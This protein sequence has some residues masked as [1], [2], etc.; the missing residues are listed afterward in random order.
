[1]QLSSIRR[2]MRLLVAASLAILMTNL[3]YGQIGAGGFPGR[4]VDIVEVTDHDDQV[5]IT[6]QFNCSV[7]YV[8]HLPASEGSEIRVQLQPFPDCGV[9]PG[10]PVASEI[11]PI[12]GGGGLV[13]AVRVDS[14]VPGQITLVFTLRKSEQFVIAQGVDPRGLRLR[15]IKPVTRK[16]QILLQPT[17]SVSNYAINLD[18]RTTPFEPEAVE[19]AHQLLQ[20]P[21][22]ISETVVEG[23]KWYR[24]RI[25]PIEQRAQANRLLEK[26]LAEYPRAWLAI[27]DDAVT[28]DL[29]ALSSEALPPVEHI[30]SDPP[31]DAAT[32]KSMLGQIRSAMSARDYPT[33]IRLL[34]K[35]QRQPEFPER[36]RVQE[37]LGLARER[38]GQLAHAKAEYE[39]YMRRYPK[40]E[41]AERI[42]LRLRILRAATAKSQS[43][44]QVSEAASRWRINGGVSQLFRYDGTRVDNTTPAGNV[45][46]G[47]TI[48]PNSTQTTTEDA[49]FNDVDFLARRRGDSID[50]MARMSAGY[51]K[52]FDAQSVGNQRRISIA[53]IELVDRSLGLLGR[54]GRQTR[55]QDGVLGTFDGLF[56]SYQWRPAWGVN[57]TAGYPVEETDAGVR[58]NRRFE[59]IALAYSPPGARWDASIFAVIQE[60]D[61]VRDRQAA[62]FEARYLASHASLVMVVDYDT[63]YHSLNTASF[64]GTVQLPARW[65]VSFDAERRNSP[66]LTTRNALIGQPAATI[67]ELEAQ[68]LQAGLPAQTIFQWARDRTPYTTDYSFT[69]TRP[70]GQRLQFSATAAV[71]QTS[72]TPASGAVDAQPGSG[73]ETTYQAQLYGSSLWFPGDFSVASLTYANTETGKV[74]TLGGSARFPFIGAWRIGPRITVNRRVLV[75]DDS[76]ELTYIPSVLL[77][78]QRGLK[79]LQF[80]VGGQL[81]KRDALLETQNTKRYYVSLSYRIGF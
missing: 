51:S 49:L 11:P 77:D 32:I 19:H 27:G 52:S 60:Y 79:L 23:Q 38:S 57:V 5:D 12:S 30:G 1:M 61:G 66:V 76:T 72:G 78:Y 31:L 22:F 50:F 18:S 68:I 26:A 16:G 48:I 58:T 35:L 10:V 42:A 80:E 20:A 70:I 15:I 17:D 36:A 53:S 65:N 34:T 54:L 74:Q 9:R 14:D 28:S 21:V 67:A 7:R 6:V 46:P 44:A 39:E 81:G 2:L 37:L 45:P 47:S 40:G 25:G 73:T 24:L 29:N 63:F 33:A 43:G 8:T 75:A 13:T 3:A 4:L 56:V 62:G 41:A 69:A 55:N 59:T 71:S 64:L